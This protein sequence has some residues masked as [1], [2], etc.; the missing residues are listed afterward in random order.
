MPQ[1]HVLKVST[2][3]KHKS[4]VEELLRR[5]LKGLHVHF[6]E[7][8]HFPFDLEIGLNR[9]LRHREPEYRRKNLTIYSR[10]SSRRFSDNYKF[11]P[12]P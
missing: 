5:Y 3:F 12:E 9:V 2:L 1:N 7:I 10:E 4:D 8:F 6:W 11:V